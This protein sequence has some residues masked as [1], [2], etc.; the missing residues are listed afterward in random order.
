MPLLLILNTKTLLWYL[1]CSFP[2]WVVAF[3]ML[4]KFTLFAIPAYASHLAL[5][6]DAYWSAGWVKLVLSAVSGALMNLSH[7][8]FWDALEPKLIGQQGFGEGRTKKIKLDANG[9]PMSPEDLAVATSI[10]RVT[11]ASAVASGDP[12]K[13]AA[14]ASFTQRELDLL[15]KCGINPWDPAAQAALKRL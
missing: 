14:A 7:S 10:A 3:Y 5:A 15:A 12:T 11:A 13:G 9:K 8:A 4:P 6:A 2:L 1:L